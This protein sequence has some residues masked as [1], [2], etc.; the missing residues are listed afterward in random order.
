M[1][2]DRVAAAV[3][4]N[5]QWCDA[6]CRAHGTPGEFTAGLWLNRHRAPRYYPNLITLSDSP[7][8]ADEAL[9]ALAE[10][11][12]PGECGVK[13]SYSALRLEHLGFVVLF[14]AQWVFRPASPPLSIP[15][16][17]QLRWA[18]VDAAGSLEA[19]EAAW[20][21][22]RDLP[23]VF[24]PALLER[25][26]VAV[27]AAYRGDTIVSGAIA[28]LTGDV[29]GISNFFTTGDPPE[30]LRANCVRAVMDAYPG[31]GLVGYEAGGEIAQSEALGF[32]RLGPLRVW[33]KQ[34]SSPEAV[35]SI[36]RPDA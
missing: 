2:T 31:R 22:R 10:G 34:G 26:D 9:R 30:P 4:N 8:A 27:L 29:I 14:D 6:V 13:D 15:R 5:A 3:Q 7:V 36:A 33:V 32:R 28:N 25:A 20:A 16:L 11:G 17:S 24:V 12:L 1:D 18:R 19:W 23:R 21:G 35:P